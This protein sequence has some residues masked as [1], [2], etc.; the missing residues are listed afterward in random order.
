MTKKR[1]SEALERTF[2]TL[3]N[4]CKISDVVASIADDRQ[5]LNDLIAYS[6]SLNDAAKEQL[7]KFKLDSAHC[8]VCDGSDIKGNCVACKEALCSKCTMKCGNCD[9]MLCKK[10]CRICYGDT[11]SAY[12]ENFI[13]TEGRK[14]NYWESDG[15][16]KKLCS[17][18]VVTTECE[19]EAQFCE[20]CLNDYDCADCDMCHGY[21]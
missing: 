3:V 10:C 2:D 20:D 13:K 11:P 6:Q 9:D 4:E 17:T 21:Y 12:D 19:R 15:C 18:C 14:R 8:F 1:S 5:A 16:G 7:N